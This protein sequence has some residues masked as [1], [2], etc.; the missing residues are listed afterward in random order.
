MT[1]NGLYESLLLMA[2][3]SNG[4]YVPLPSVQ[5]SYGPFDSLAEAK[6]DLANTFKDISNVPRGYTFCVIE[7]NKPQEYWFTSA[8]DWASVQKKNTSS[9]SSVTIE[10]ILFKEEGDY[11]KY[12]TDGGITWYHWSTRWKGG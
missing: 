8:G 4:E 9:S 2:R 11:I 10:G 6:T 1:Y 12:S 7:N 5:A 3:L